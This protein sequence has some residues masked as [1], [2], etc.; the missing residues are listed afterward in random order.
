MRGRSILGLGVVVFMVLG[1]FYACGGGSSPVTPAPTPPPTA[2]TGTLTIKGAPAAAGALAVQALGASFAPPAMLPGTPTSVR[3]RMYKVYLSS[4]ADCSSPALVQDKGAA[5]DY[6]D[7]TGRPTLFSATVTAGSYNCLAV[8]IS[9]IMKFTADTAAAA[10]SGGV[11]VVGRENDF[12]IL[13]VEDPTEN[14]YDVDTGGTVT[15]QGSYGGP[16]PQDVF[17]FIST[18]TAAVTA[19]N[20][21]VHVHQLVS[22]ANPIVIKA[23]QATNAAFVFDFSNRMA[24]TTDGRGGAWCWLEGAAL[25]FVAQ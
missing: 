8:K 17:L 18:N 7:I 21:R 24:V 3:T 22:L 9:D 4:N 25:Q 6:Q 23:S 2:T 19:A 11:C 15:G 1:V 16:V 13:K 20:R 12:D 10:A 5:A 14:W